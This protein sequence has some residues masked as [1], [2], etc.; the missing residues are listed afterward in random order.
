MTTDQVQEF[1]NA[2]KNDPKLQAELQKPDADPVAIAAQA[3]FT[4]SGPQLH[5]SIMELS[6]E[7]LDHAAGGFDARAF[8]TIFRAC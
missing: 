8:K 1:L 4:I 2:V 5:S 3:G 7:E 6:D